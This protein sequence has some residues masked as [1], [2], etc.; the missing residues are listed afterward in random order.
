MDDKKKLIDPFIYDEDK[1]SKPPIQIGS[2]FINPSTGL[3]EPMEFTEKNKSFEEKTYI[4]LYKIASNDMEL[5]EMYNK[6]YSV[7]VGRTDAYL[8]IKDKLE[9]GLDIDIHR[10]MI[11]TETLQTETNTGNKRYYLMPLGDCISIYSFCITVKE[12]FQDDFDIEAYNNNGDIPDEQN[13]LMP[14]QPLTAEQQEY[15]KLL[16]ASMARDKFFEDMT[17]NVESHNI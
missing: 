9:S 16:D 11:I 12:Y 8:D 1:A 10:S 4:I 2:N 15:R 6:L 17:R 14:K 7:C 13:V 5:E 3:I